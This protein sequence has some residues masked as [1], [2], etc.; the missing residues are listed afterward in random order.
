MSSSNGNFDRRSVLELRPTSCCQRCGELAKFSI[1][2]SGSV[3]G[4][5][6]VNTGE[7]RL[8]IAEHVLVPIAAHRFVQL[9]QTSRRRARA[10]AMRFS[11]VRKHE[12]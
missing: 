9:R 8:Q 5:R 3:F 1:W 2:C 7:A 6:C 11:R 12:N 10:R 4:L